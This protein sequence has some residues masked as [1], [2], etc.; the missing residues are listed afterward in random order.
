MRRMVTDRVNTIIE[1]FQN[2]N[3]TRLVRK[4]HIP[5]PAAEREGCKQTEECVRVVVDRVV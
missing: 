4:E 1:I 2:E 3:L 5:F